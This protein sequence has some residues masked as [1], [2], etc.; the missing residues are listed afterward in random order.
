MP[1]WAWI[2]NIIGYIFVILLIVGVTSGEIDERELTTLIVGSI[3]LIIYLSLIFIFIF[4]KRKVGILSAVVGKENIIIL[5]HK[6]EMR[7]Q[8]KDFIQDVHSLTSI[9]E[10]RTSESLGMVRRKLIMTIASIILVVVFIV[11]FMLILQGL[12]GL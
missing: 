4:L 12:G 2:L 10:S 11:I 1:L 9:R 6:E 5:S 7:N 8:A 3:V